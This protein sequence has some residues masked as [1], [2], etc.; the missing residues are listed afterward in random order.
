MDSAVE[1]AKQIV[2]ALEADPGDGLTEAGQMMV[3]ISRA[4]IDSQSQ[5]ERMREALVSFRSIVVEGGVPRY[6]VVPGAALNSVIEDLVDPI[7]RA[8][9]TKEEKRP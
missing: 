7:L 9:L 1:A 5:V 4:L 3:D 6:S 8:A 2:A